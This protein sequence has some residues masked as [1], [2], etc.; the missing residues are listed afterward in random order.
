MLAQ[1]P[2]PLHFLPRLSAR[3]GVK[4]WVKRDDLTGFGLSGNKVR[5]LESLLSEAL[6]SGVDTVITT[7]GIQSNHCRA[8]A[9]ACRQM[10][11][12]PVLLLR[13]EPQ[14][15]PDGNLLLDQLLGAEIH[16]CTAETYRDR[17]DQVMETLASNCRSAGKRP[18]VIPEGGS[19]GRGALAFVRAAEEASNQLSETIDVTFVAVGSGGTL[20]GLALGQGI[21]FIYGVAVCDDKAY[22]SAR[23]QE[24]AAQAHDLGAPSLPEQGIGWDVLEGYQGPA[25]GVATPHIWETI[26]WV[27]ENEGLLLDPVYTGKAMHALIS[28][29][30]GGRLEGNLLFWH[31]GGA[32]GL[33]G[34][35]HELMESC[36][37]HHRHFEPS[38]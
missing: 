38:L 7:G 10:G 37:S 18:L 9:V 31:T 32:F 28:E 21:G 24:I 25:Y 36:E 5:K 13:G 34:R 15:P 23:V 12:H 19:N 8:T 33:F 4:V 29:V 35:G 26:R 16:Y 17:R 11:L 6:Q 22:F 27:A 1:R 2:T 30:E 14:S 3:L 20:A